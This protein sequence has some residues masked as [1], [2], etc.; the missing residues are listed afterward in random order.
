[1]GSSFYR[2]HRARRGTLR[3]VPGSSGTRY[4]HP[5][6]R[7]PFGPAAR[8]LSVLGRICIRCS[9]QLNA[10]GTVNRDKVCVEKRRVASKDT[11][12]RP[13]FLKIESCI[14]VQ[15]LMLPDARTIAAREF[16]PLHAA[17]WD[18][19]LYEKPG[20]SCS[21]R[22]GVVRGASRRARLYIRYRC[23]SFIG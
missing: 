4:D 21:H 23:V 15:G 6:P 9:R 8:G 14:G 11:R 19:C 13:A 16:L 3:L 22:H 5:P 17:S 12:D 20:Y 7:R 18:V 2:D 10:A 1:M